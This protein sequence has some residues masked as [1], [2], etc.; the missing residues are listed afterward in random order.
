MYVLVFVF[1]FFLES[2]NDSG[3]FFVYFVFHVYV[4]H[5]FFS[6]P[7][8]FS[9]LPIARNCVESVKYFPNR[10]NSLHFIMSYDKF[11]GVLQLI[12][13]RERN[14]YS[15]FYLLGIEYNGI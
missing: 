12:Y 9:C 13:E 15:F 5:L 1:C 11:F 14:T 7:F 2:M 8:F 4:S 3:Y 10:I 6:F